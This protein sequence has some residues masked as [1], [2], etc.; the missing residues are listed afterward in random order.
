M[1]R[2]R[3]VTIWHVAL[4][5]PW[6][7]AAASLRQPFNDNSYLWHVRAGDLQIAEKAVVTADPFSFTRAGSAW[8]TQSW[9]AELLYSRL[10]SWLGLQ[11][12]RLIVTILATLLFLLIGLIAYRRS[13]SVPSVVLFLTASAI[14]I[15]GFLVPRPVIFSLALLAAVVVADSDRRMRWTLPVLMWAWASVHA[16]FALGLAYLALRAVGRGIGWKRLIDLFIVGLPTLVTAH[17]LGV[18]DFLLGFFTNRDALGYLDEWAK[19]D[20]L[21]ISVLPLFA[22]LL[23]LIWLSGKGQLERCDWWVIV[24]F[25]A[26]AFSSTRAVPP[27]WIVLSPILGRVDV[28]FRSTSATRPP[29]AAAVAGALLVLPFLLPDRSGIDES[30]FPLEAGQHLETAHVVHDDVVGGWL[31]YSQWPDRQVFIDDRAEVHGAEG[32]EELLAVERG[33]ERW[34]GV[35]E[36]YP[37]TE[38]LLTLSRAENLADELA[39]EGWSETYRDEYFVVMKSEK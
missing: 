36:S 6:I 38:V 17:G 5:V 22:G 39:E 29:L 4:L 27:A 28:R 12:P 1:S 9:L 19:P 30:R 37:I 13:R 18:F 34:R 3:N 23:A 24:P 11:A 32:F 8:R 14:V 35:F 20:L 21:S 10:D 16:S 15:A 33:S 2:L 7:V 31:I 25:L 26:L